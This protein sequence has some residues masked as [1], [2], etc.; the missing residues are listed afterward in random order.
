MHDDLKTFSQKPTQKFCGKPN[1]FEKPKFSTKTEK[2]G[3][4]R[5]MHDERVKKRHTRIIKCTLR[6]KNSQVGGL[7]CERKVWEDKKTKTVERD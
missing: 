2:L 6:L 1:N 5:E 7:E 3:K 4:K